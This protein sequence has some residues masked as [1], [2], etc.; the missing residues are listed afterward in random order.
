MRVPSSL[1]RLAEPP[2]RGIVL[3]RDLPDRLGGATL[4]VSPDVA[5]KYWRRSPERLPRS[6]APVTIV[7]TAVAELPTRVQFVVAA[8]GRAASH[9]AEVEGWTQTGGS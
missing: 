1:R 2:S 5:L 3:Q 8:R 6:Y 7:E 9:L 4:H